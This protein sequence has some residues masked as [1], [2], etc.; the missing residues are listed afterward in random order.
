MQDGNSFLPWYN[1]SLVEFLNSYIKP[2]MNVFEYGCGFSTL[3]YAQKNCQVKAVETK[4]EWVQKV[5]SFAREY[6]LEGRILI[7]LSKPH[8]IPM[9]LQKLDIA[10]DVIVV[11]SLRRIECL[12]EAKKAY[13]KGII[14]LDNSERENLQTANEIMHGFE[15]KVFKGNGVHR[16]GESEAKVFFK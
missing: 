4:T 12:T 15:C 2:E 5:Q 8:E 1:F 10:F 9:E 16:N 11:D 7:T 14:I 3:Y 13:K 6:N